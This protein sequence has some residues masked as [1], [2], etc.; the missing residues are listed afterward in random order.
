MGCLDPLFYRYFGKYA[1]DHGGQQAHQRIEIGRRNLFQIRDQG[2]GW[3]CHRQPLQAHTTDPDPVLEGQ[4]TGHI[5]ELKSE[6]VLGNSLLHRQSLRRVP[7][8]AGLDEGSVT[9]YSSCV[10]DISQLFIKKKKRNYYNRLLL[11]ARVLS[12]LVVLTS[13]VALQEEYNI[14]IHIS[15]SFVLPHNL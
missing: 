10:S 15:P 11:S 5:A 3:C 14:S 1:G 4:Q 8:H 2:C 9:I 12:N 7:E 6:K 13:C